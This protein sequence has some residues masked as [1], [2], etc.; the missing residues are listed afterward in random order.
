[1]AGAHGGRARVSFGPLRAEPL[2][3]DAPRKGHQAEQKRRDQ[4][5]RRTTEWQPAAELAPGAP[6]LPAAPFHDGPLFRRR[7][8]PDQGCPDS[9]AFFL[10]KFIS[11]TVMV[12]TGRYAL[13]NTA[14]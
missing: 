9:S 7:P 12:F 3:F 8:R 4:V 14:E 10:G 11:D 2:H 1:M 5:R 6:L 13:R